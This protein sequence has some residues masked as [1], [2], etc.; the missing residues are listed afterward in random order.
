MQ[1]ES[2]TVCFAAGHPA[3]AGHFP[4][5][6]MVPGVLLLDALPRN[7][8]GKLPRDVLEALARFHQSPA[9]QE[10]PPRAE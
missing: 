10:G 6:P 8:T 9:V 3:F 5:R 2:T 4:G 7:A 1:S